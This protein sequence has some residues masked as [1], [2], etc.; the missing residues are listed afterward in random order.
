MDHAI[1]KQILS[2][3]DKRSNSSI[4]FLQELI[5]LT[6]KGELAVQNRVAAALAD[7][8]CRVDRLTY[9]PEDVPVLHEFASATAMNSE[10]R[11][12]IIATFPGSGGGKS[13]IFFAHP[14]AEPVFTRLTSASYAAQAVA[15][16]SNTNTFLPVAGRFSGK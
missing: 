4:A 13:M 16:G 3:A 10:M 5:A 8:G 6:P 12:S 15:L 7:L 1:W 11:E 14:D 2:E 9:R